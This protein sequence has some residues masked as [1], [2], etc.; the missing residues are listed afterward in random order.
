MALWAA[1]RNENR[2]ERL[3]E[4]AYSGI[5]AFPSF[6]MVWVLIAASA[7]GE[8]GRAER[9]LWW[10]WA[11][12][13]ALSCVTTGMHSIADVLAGAALT[14]MTGSPMPPLV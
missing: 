9:L 8:G 4:N 12:L 5:G 1:K 11:A 2:L 3:G 13:V 10:K 6:H 14:T 7:L